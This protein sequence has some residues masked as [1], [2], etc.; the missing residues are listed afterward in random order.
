[1]TERDVCE[2]SRM[3]WNETAAIHKR[4]S[5]SELLEAVQNP[6]FCTFDAVEQRV[7]EGINLAGKSVVQAVS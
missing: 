7:F 2:A 6:D 4:V 5:L 3:G 1:M